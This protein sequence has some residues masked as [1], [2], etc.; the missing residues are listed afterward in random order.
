[1]KKK[2]SEYLSYTFRCLGRGLLGLF[3]GLLSAL[4]FFNSRAFSETFR[5]DPSSHGVKVSIAKRWSYLLGGLVGFLLF[6]LLP[7]DYVA[8]S[9]PLAIKGLILSFCLAFGIYE[10]YRIYR[11][12][13]AKETPLAIVFLLVGLAVPVLFHFFTIKVEN[14]LTLGGFAILFGVSFAA[15]FLL[16]SGI[17]LGTAFSVTSLYLV[18][19]EAFKS[20]RGEPFNPLF[21]GSLILGILLGFALSRPLSG[22][23]F[24]MSQN[25]LALGFHLSTLVL[26]AA[27]EI[28]PPYF[29]EITTSEMAQLFTILAITIAGLGLGLAF[30]YHAYRRLNKD[31]RLEDE[32]LEQNTKRI[33]TK[34]ADKP[35]LNYHDILV[36][37]LLEETAPIPAEKDV[38]IDGIDLAKLKAIQKE[39]EER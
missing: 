18:F 21:F 23:K 16:F 8:E 19:Y 20:Q 25:A 37:G 7:V 10:A 39:M 15:G 9:Y 36:D 31:E 32:R 17:S 30:T 35:I 2:R 28:K 3:A 5:L 4:P 12:R 24:T 26:V 11:S 22:K 27:F 14:I 29:T 13:N 33:E 38:K 6:F 1:M 34:E